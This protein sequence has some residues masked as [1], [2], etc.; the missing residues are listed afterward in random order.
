MAI[1]LAMAAILAC[2]GMQALDDYLSRVGVVSLAHGLLLGYGQIFVARGIVQWGGGSLG[3]P[4]VVLICIASVAMSTYKIQRFGSR[5]VFAFNFG[6][7]LGLVY[8]G[9]SLT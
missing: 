6:V 8:G 3:W 7:A 1:L 9:I 4:V 2:L 5:W